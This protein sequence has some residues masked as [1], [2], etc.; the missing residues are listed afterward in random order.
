MIMKRLSGGNE[1]DS[2]RR[3]VEE[4]TAYPLRESVAFW[5]IGEHLG[6]Q[7]GLKSRAEEL[8]RY[9]RN[10][11]AAIRGMNDDTSR[12]VTATVDGELALYARARTGLDIL[13]IEPR[14]WAA[15]PNLNETYSYFTYAQVA[16]RSIESRGLILGLD[17]GHDSSRGHSQYLGW[18]HSA[19]MGNTAGSARATASHDLSRAHG[20]LSRDRISCRRRFDPTRTGPDAPSGS[21]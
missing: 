15:M 21:K 8:A 3:I 5:E 14:M 9:S 7:R 16:D 4:M 19:F 13:G 1:S 6:R 12:L 20:R 11:L 18:R 17:P 2:A 10:A